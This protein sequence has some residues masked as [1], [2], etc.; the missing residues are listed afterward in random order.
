MRNKFSL[1]NFFNWLTVRQH[2]LKSFSILR[3]IY[4]IALL[5]LYVPSMSEGSMLWGEASF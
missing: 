5:A 4:G 3:I 2:N 1:T